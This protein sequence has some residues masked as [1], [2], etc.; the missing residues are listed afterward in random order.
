MESEAIVYEDQSKVNKKS[1]QIN[2]GLRQAGE[3]LKKAEKLKYC[4][5]LEV[6]IFIG[7]YKKSLYFSKLQ[8][9][10]KRI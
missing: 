6:Q 10:Y 2:E 1:N 9:L 7:L 3:L 8:A 4:K 5:S